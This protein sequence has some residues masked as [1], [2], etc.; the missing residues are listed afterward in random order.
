MDDDDNDDDGAV[1]VVR[2]ENR[3]VITTVEVEIVCDGRV[4]SPPTDRP[5]LSLS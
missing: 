1:E 2:L 5:P 4:D 3:G